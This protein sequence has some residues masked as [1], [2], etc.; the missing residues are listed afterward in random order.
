MSRYYQAPG[1]IP[2]PYGSLII[3]CWANNMTL[4][5]II[6]NILHMWWVV[7]RT[8]GAANIMVTPGDHGDQTHLS[9]FL[10]QFLKQ[11]LENQHNSRNSTFWVLDAIASHQLVVVS[12]LVTTFEMLENF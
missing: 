8:Q 12:Q 10:D 4:G 5:W 11:V 3:S 1:H 9:Q 6:L 7:G 2:E